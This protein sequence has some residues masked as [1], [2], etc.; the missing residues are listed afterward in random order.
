[1]MRGGEHNGQTPGKQ[2]VGIRVVREGREPFGYG[3]A[4]LRELVVKGLLIGTVGSLSLYIPVLLDYLW[5]LW[6]E[7]NRAL[8][9]MVASTR[10]VEA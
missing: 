3:Y 10:V 6:D 5:P 2:I 7:E 4:L 1:M 8:R 9:D